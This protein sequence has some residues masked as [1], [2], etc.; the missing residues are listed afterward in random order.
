[1][2]EPVKRKEQDI[3]KS[4]ASS[5]IRIVVQKFYTM[6]QHVWQFLLLKEKSESVHFTPFL[7]PV[8]IKNSWHNDIFNLELGM[9]KVGLSEILI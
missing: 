7:I 5:E 2:H 8:Y 3:C 4:L 6:F 9:G 1:M